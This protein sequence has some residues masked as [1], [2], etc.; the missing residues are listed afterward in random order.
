MR[1]SLTDLHE[2]SAMMCVRPRRAGEGVD[3]MTSALGSGTALDHAA[4]DGVLDELLS[5]AGAIVVALTDGAVRTPLPDDPRFAAVRTL[6]GTE[7]TVIDFTAPADRMVQV[8]AWE[9]A[10]DTGV[11]RATVRLCSDPDRTFCSTIVDGRHRYGVWFNVLVA[12]D[13]LDVDVKGPQPDTPVPAPPPP[14]T[15]VVHKNLYGVIT[16]VDE[17]L[18]R[19]LGWASAEMLGRRSLEFI[20]PDDHERAVAQWLEMR[21]TRRSQH[22]RVRHRRRDG[23]WLW[24]ELENTFLSLDDPD[25]LVAICHLTDISDEMAAHEAL[26]RR[27]RLFHR[28]AEALPTG[29]LLVNLDQEIVFANGRLADILGVGPAPTL[30]EQLA[31]V[32]PDDR[33]LLLRLLAATFDDHVDRQV[34]IDVFP[35]R[36]GARRRCAA[37]VTALT[38]DEGLPGA[39]VTLS[40][41]T[42]SASMRE[43]L[44]R[45]ATYDALTGCANRDSTFSVLQTLLD[46]GQPA[47]VLFLDVD[48]L[49]AVNDSFGHAAGDE[50]LTRTAQVVTAHARGQ[51]VLGRIGGDEFLLICPLISKPEEARAIAQR[52]QRALGDTVAHRNSRDRLRAS[53]GVTI[54]TAPASVH[55]VVTRADQAMYRCKRQPDG[56]P[57]FLGAAA[58]DLAPTPP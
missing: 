10:H 38:T 22:V 34:E 24:V 17:R 4:L 25:G 8:R 54:A 14:R 7:E 43:E 27:E 49:K 57:V 52:I 44:R 9:C 16:F 46:A 15:A 51:D 23:S 21:A 37:S 35:P 47:A 50:V 58:E 20:H 28:L 32:A 1:E 31:S 42:D 36:T 13:R 29:V 26:R 18:E 45:R 11:S 48:Q 3:G 5:R 56:T 6:P 39:L 33:T 40:D 2:R 12:E 41:V 53:I 55:A 30:Q 19:M